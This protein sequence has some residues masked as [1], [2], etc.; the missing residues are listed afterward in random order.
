MESIIFWTTFSALLSSRNAYL[1][2]AQKTWMNR[3]RENGN[4]FSKMKES[5]A[6]F[7][8]KLDNKAYP[9]FRIVQRDESVIFIADIEGRSITLFK[10]E[11]EEWFGNAE[12]DLID[13]IGNA[14]EEA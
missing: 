11:N 7:T 4:K 3:M 14:I 10:G 9:V 6:R 1:S 8:I 5:Q 12:Q 13:K 2:S